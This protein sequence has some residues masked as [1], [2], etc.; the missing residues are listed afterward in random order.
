[1]TRI[2]I[3]ALAPG[4]SIIGVAEDDEV[5]VIGVDPP[6]LLRGRLI[7]PVHFQY[8]RTTVAALVREGDGT[9]RGA[10]V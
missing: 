10:R 2:E 3:E 6:F 7:R 5:R 4:D 8:N 9:I 1:M